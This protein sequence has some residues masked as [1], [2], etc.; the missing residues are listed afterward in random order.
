MIQHEHDACQYVVYPYLRLNDDGCV[1][2][3][4]FFSDHFEGMNLKKELSLKQFYWLVLFPS[5]FY[6]QNMIEN[7]SRVDI[8]SYF[9]ENVS[10][11]HQVLILQNFAF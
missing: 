8:E 5:H 3:M 11:L 1:L 7:W 4:Y 10:E 2:V 6:F 9:E